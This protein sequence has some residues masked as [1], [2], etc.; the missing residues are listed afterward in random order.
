MISL[1]VGR[2]KESEPRAREEILRIYATFTVPQRYP[3]ATP[4]LLCGS[5]ESQAKSGRQAVNT[6]VWFWPR[7][8]QF[9]PTL[10]S[11]VPPYLKTSELAIYNVA[12]S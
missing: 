5:R 6:T 10:V 7:C 9:W 1:E 12:L 11:D 3:N 8:L 4:R 2:D